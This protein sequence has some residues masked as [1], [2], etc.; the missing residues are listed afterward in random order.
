MKWK[1]SINKFI[2]DFKEREQIC[3]KI[4]FIVKKNLINKNHKGQKHIPWRLYLLRKILQI[5]SKKNLF[6]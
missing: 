3:V 1:E 5:S 4:F 2:V 6:Y